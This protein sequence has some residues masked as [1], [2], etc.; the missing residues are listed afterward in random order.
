MTRPTTDRARGIA[1]LRRPLLLGVAWAVSAS[2]A[3]GLGFLAVS[4]LDASASPGTPQA[5]A[6][7]SSGAGPA[8]TAAAPTASSATGEFTT[9]AGTVYATC[10][11]GQ[12]VLAG[13]PVAGWWIDD[14]AQPGKVEFEDGT[15]HL[16]V[17]VACVDGTPTFTS[18]GAR[19]EDGA[20]P[21]TSTRSSGPT[22]RSTE[23]VSTASATASEDSSGRNG[24]GHGS[25]DPAG[26][27]S[28]GRDGGG[29]GAE[30]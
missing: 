15:H 18:D 28:S 10:G 29:H 3:V 19:V 24:G 23:P 20:T 11:S 26:D 8:A 4:L 12:P 30:D 22:R 21:E 1:A 27:D 6:A 13:V 2:A 17:R 14:S 16:E 25:D 9:P 7:T 5:A